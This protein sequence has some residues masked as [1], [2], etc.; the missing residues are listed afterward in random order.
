MTL[1]AI[2][3]KSWRIACAMLCAGVAA[4]LLS[5]TKAAS[6]EDWPTKPIKMIVSLGV[7]GGMDNLAR[8]MAPFLQQEL[9]Q[10]VVVEN[11][12]GAGEL[13]AHTYYLQQPDDGY[14]ILVTVAMPY[15]AVHLLAQNATYSID[16][17]KYINLPRNDYTMI[18]VNKK[19]PRFKTVAEFVDAVR[20]NPGKYSVGVGAPSGADYINLVLFLNALGLDL[21]DVRSVNYNTSGEIRTALLGDQL[22]VGFIAGLPTIPMADLLDSIMVFN[23]ERMEPWTNAPAFEEAMAQLGAKGK[24]QFVAGALGGFLVQSSFEKK[25]PERWKKLVDAFK[26]ISDDPAK[27]KLLK[28]RDLWADWYGPEKSG[29]MVRSTFKAFEAQRGL[30]KP[31]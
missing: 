22:D 18:A 8:S 17:F 4:G 30:L 9:G 10:P 2:Q 15:M 6:A 23:S 11:R 29:E 19:N 12:P 16:D 24:G 26:K 1:L 25:Y 28:D 3:R 20:K 5:M 21:K 27:V 14:T 7:G 13:L 31:E